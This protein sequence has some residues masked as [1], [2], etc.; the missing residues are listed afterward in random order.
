[1]KISFT[2]FRKELSKNMRGVKFII[3]L[4]VAILIAI[5]PVFA[6][7]YSINDGAQKAYK[8]PRTQVVPIQDPE[9]GGQYEL[10]IK[11]PDEYLEDSN[12]TYPVIYFTDA[13]YHIEILS[14]ST[15]N[16]MED[17]ILV[18]ISWQKD[19]KEDVKQKYGAHASRF[20]DYSFWKTTNPEHSLLKFGQASNH[21]SFIRNE[22]F[23][24]VEQNYRTDPNDR[25]Y[26]GYSLGGVF[27]A[28][29]LVTQ[30]ETFNKY[31]L[32]SPSVDL[33]TKYK[34]EFTTKKLNANVFISR[35]TLEEEELREPISEFVNLLEARKDNT[36]SIESVVIEGDHQTAFPLTG[37]RSITWLSS[38]T[39]DGDYPV[40]EGPYFGQKPPGI[41]AEPF[42]PGIV[43]KEGWE[44]EG[45]F[46]PSMKEF[47]FVT[48]SSKETPI[49]V[50]GFRQQDNTWKKY[51]EFPRRGEISFSPDGSRMHMAEGYK[52][53]K[54]EGWSERK[55]L[56]PM[57][58]RDDWGIMRL[59]ASSKGTYVFDDYK[60]GDVIRIS[61]IK[62]GI[63]QEPKK[64]GTMVNTGK[65][66]AHPFIAPDESYLIWDSEREGGYG[67]SDLYI[68]FRQKD[69]AW[70]PAIN[71]GDKVNTDK[72]DAYA[73]VTSDGKYIL[74]NRRIDDGI[75]NDNMNVDIYWVDAQIIETLRPKQ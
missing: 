38:L 62:D 57:F 19:I 63:R 10:Y 31:I 70:G 41:I 35:G 17:V 26:F 67:G 21:L 7:D 66:T 37:V 49:T 73:S 44:I 27:G 59:T 9:S 3:M 16:I 43:S 40:L 60:S 14:T 46:A 6:Q 34:I 52:D 54:G 45:V 20:E 53:R 13:I 50:I 75:N 42:A 47:Y 2:E 15:E 29:I 39:K 32:G 55:S 25:S 65:W 58:D 69:G 1:M 36:L 4:F 12:K 5:N 11:L 74:F 56:G 68:S 48:R 23:S 71:M 30:P 61:T 64:M 28:Y 22:V 8:M 51:I 24:Y 72:W 33:L 18:G